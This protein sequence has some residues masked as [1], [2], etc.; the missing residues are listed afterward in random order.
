M[1]RPLLGS[2]S[3]LPL[4]TLVDRPLT[5]AKPDPAVYH[6]DPV[7]G[8]P[9][10]RP[11][12]AAERLRRLAIHDIGPDARQTIEAVLMAA[13]EAEQALAIQR[14]RIRHLESL[15][16]TDE[17]TGLLNRRGFQIELDRALAR[18]Q[19]NRETGL[20]VLCDLNRFKA[21]NDTHGHMAG[22]AVLR[23][24]ADLLQRKT[25]R[26]DYVARF[27]GDEFAVLMT[28]STW[29]QAARR[30]ALLARAIDDLAVDWG[31]RQIQV[32]ASFGSE[33]YHW[34][35]QAETL[36]FLTDRALYRR[37]RPRLVPFPRPAS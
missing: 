3:P 32:G 1:A 12:V 10:P 21:I 6:F 22:D 28:H 16:V 7:A 8:T 20:M 25:R 30:V 17:M 9:R 23:A 34:G 18:A 35:T 11:W 29:A 27:G 13:A 4:A 2:E 5:S 26:T 33:G 36:L 19:R 37:K 31:G 24:V 14:A 15:S